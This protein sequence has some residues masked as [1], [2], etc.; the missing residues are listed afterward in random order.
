MKRKETMQYTLESIETFEMYCA[1]LELHPS[2]RK[3]TSGSQCLD[4]KINKMSKLYRADCPILQ[5]EG[6]IQLFETYWNMIFTYEIQVS[7]NIPTRS[8]RHEIALTET[9][10]WKVSGTADKIQAY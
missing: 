6:Q 5:N 2:T 7:S 8:E 3:W 1:E 9:L 10:T 4:L